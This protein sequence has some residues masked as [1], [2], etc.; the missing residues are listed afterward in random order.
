MVTKLERAKIKLIKQINAYFT[1]FT[2]S[3]NQDIIKNHYVCYYY[4]FSNYLLN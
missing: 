3:A 4:K 2:I 1:A